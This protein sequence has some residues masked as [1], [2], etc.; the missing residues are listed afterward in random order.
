GECRAKF[1]AEPSKYVSSLSR[2]TAAEPAP[3]GTIYTC[4]MH[5]E[6]RPVGPGNCPMCGMALEPVLVEGDAGP[7]PELI[8]MTRRLWIGLA[9]TIPVVAIE[10]GGHLTKPP[11]LLGQGLSNWI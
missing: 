6:I 7:N 2:K 5:P 11:V 1:E 10:M 3:E 8:D 9:L 4:P